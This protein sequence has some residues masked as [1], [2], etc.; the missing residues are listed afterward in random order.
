MSLSKYAQKMV[1][2]G[3]PTSYRRGVKWEARLCA[4]ERRYDHPI[5]DS[6]MSG[7]NFRRNTA[8]EA[9]VYRP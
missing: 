9:K 2:R 5:H 8:L 1:A 6:V 7:H 3:N 4:C